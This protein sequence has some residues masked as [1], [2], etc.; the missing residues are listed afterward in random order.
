MKIIM[1]VAHTIDGFIA[2]SADQF[3]DW[4]SK[5][6]K[7]MFREETKKAG[8]MIM[9]MTTYKTIGKPLPE[10][11]NI[12]LTSK[13][14]QLESI[15]D[16]LEYM[17]AT[18]EE[19]IAD[20]SARNFETVCVI[21][22]ARTY[23]EFLKAKLIDEIWLTIEPVIFGQGVTTFTDDIMGVKCYLTKFIN[24]NENSLQLRF[25]LEYE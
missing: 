17:N 25:R 5:E 19:V 9:G 23:T 6:D 18:P 2:K 21:G 12:V 1:I 22:G 13:A 16:T 3:I 11:L 4:S 15:P 8:V 24:L 20:L 7:K 10:R 14:D